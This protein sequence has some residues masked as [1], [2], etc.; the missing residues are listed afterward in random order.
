MIASID[1]DARK[2][3]LCIYYLDLSEGVS[4]NDAQ[5]KV[6]KMF[7]DKKHQADFLRVLQSLYCY[8]SPWGYIFSMGGSQIG[9]NCFFV[10]HGSPLEVGLLFFLLISTPTLSCL[11][12]GHFL[13][14]IHFK[15]SAVFRPSNFKCI[16]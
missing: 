2:L 10:R 13:N 16:L 5:M 12:M 4:P 14:D 11:P 9:G 6:G 3:A 8:S 7:T 1:I 15:M